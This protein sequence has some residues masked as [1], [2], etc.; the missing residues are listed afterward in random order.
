[1]SEY[2]DALDIEYNYWDGFYAIAKRDIEPNETIL[3]VPYQ[4]IISNCKI[5]SISHNTIQ[6][7]TIPSKN[8]YNK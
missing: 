3:N 4:L 6:L 8:K 5:R 1:M 2:S 7:M